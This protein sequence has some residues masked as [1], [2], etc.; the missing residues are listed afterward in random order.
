MKVKLL[1][2]KEKMAQMEEQMVLHM[3]CAQ[4]DEAANK[5]K[6][7]AHRSVQK[8]LEMQESALAMKAKQ[9]RIAQQFE[10]LV[11]RLEQGTCD[12]RAAIVFRDLTAAFER[13]GDH[14]NNVAKRLEEIVRRG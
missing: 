6:S 9:A 14:L 1:M 7:K 12:L 5:A 8:A 13:I 2:I 11:H 3:D 4:D 10:T